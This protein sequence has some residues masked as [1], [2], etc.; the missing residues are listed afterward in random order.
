MSDIGKRLA[1]VRESAGFSQIPFAQKLG[2]SQSSYK[3]YERGASP[4][5]VSLIARICED[6]EVSPAWLVLGEGAIKSELNGELVEG[7]VLAVEKFAEAHDLDPPLERKA[8]LIRFVYEEVISGR[9]FGDKE[10][11]RIFNT[12]M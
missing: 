12:V 9:D 4:V 6:Y 3:N 10:L 7:A 5:P 11:K 1:V 8:K 2:V